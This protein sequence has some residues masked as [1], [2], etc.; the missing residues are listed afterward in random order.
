MV[1]LSLF[2]QRQHGITD[3]HVEE[4]LVNDALVKVG[5]S[6]AVVQQTLL[7]LVVSRNNQLVPGVPLL[8]EQFVKEASMLDD[9]HLLDVRVRF[10]IFA[11]FGLLVL[12]YALDFTINHGELVHQ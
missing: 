11:K 1:S 6:F 4:G 3:K 2:L 9:K 5:D 7:A 10:L 8:V 12:F